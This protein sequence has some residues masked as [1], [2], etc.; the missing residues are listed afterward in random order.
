MALSSE[1][2]RQ[3]S[4]STEPME[5]VGGMELANVCKA[6]WQVFRKV[7][8]PQGTSLEAPGLPAALIIVR[9]ELS[10]PQSSVLL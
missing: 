5:G 6:L 4:D 9:P 3:S 2:N 10:S 1:Q 8:D 7:A